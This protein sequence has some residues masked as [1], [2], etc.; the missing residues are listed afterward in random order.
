MTRI[1]KCSTSAA[2][3]ALLRPDLHEESGLKE[4]HAELESTDKWKLSEAGQPK[5][6]LPKDEPDV[7][8]Q[9]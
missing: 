3:T 4:K 5:Q 1:P 2:A 8:H 7:F 6:V 9:V